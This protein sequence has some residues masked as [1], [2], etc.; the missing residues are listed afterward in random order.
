ME[1][2]FP[3]AFYWMAIPTLIGAIMPVIAQFYPVNEFFW[4]AL[5]VAIGGAVIGIFATWRQM[6]G[7][8]PPPGVAAD[9]NVGMAP[10]R[11]GLSRWFWG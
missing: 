5:V 9:P 4:S 2:K 10:R 6:Q 3:G 7:E 8:K 1:F 11:G